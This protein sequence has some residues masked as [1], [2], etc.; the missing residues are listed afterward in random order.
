ML[1][2]T[3]N[4]LILK[5]GTSLLTCQNPN[6]D[7]RIMF[8]SWFD[9]FGHKKYISHIQTIYYTNAKCSYSSI[10]VLHCNKIASDRFFFIN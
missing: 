10:C 1:I 7:G 6:T 8:Y 3:I 9:I 2:M 5:T 4:N